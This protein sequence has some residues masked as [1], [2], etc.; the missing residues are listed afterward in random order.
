M[1]VVR[2]IHKE[3]QWLLQNNKYKMT[4]WKNWSYRPLKHIVT[5]KRPGR[6]DNAT[7]ND[8]IIGA[9]TETSKKQNSEANHVVAWTISFRA[10]GC[11]IVTLYGHK[12]SSMMECIKKII[13]SME[14]EETIIYFHNLAYDYMFLRKF[15]FREFG[16][17]VK[18]LNTKP[19]YPIS[20]NFQNGLILKDSLILAQRALEKWAK[21]MDVEHQKAVGSWDYDAYRHQDHKFTRS[22][23]KY[24]EYDTLALVECLDK[25]AINLRKNIATLPMTATGIPRGELREIG[26]KLQVHQSY[27]AKAVPEFDLGM[28]LI[29]IYHG[30]FTHSNRH[31]I[32]ETVL[33]EIV[34]YD[35]SSSYPGQLL[36]EKYPCDRFQPIPDCNI[37]Y[38]LRNMENYA[39]M[40]T[41]ILI[42]PRLKDD[43]I[44]MPVL[45]YSKCVNTINAILD[46]GRILA[47]EYV[48]IEINEIDLRMILK[49][50]DFDKHICSDV[51]VATK[52]YL[53]RWF[54]DY[55]YKCYKEKCELKNG[56]PILYN[57][58]KSRLNALYGMCC[59]KP[60][61][62]EIVEDYT[63][64]E[65]SDK[66]LDEAEAYAKYVKKFTSINLY[67]TG[68]WCTSY[69]MEKLMI[70]GSCCKKWIYSDTDSCYGMDWNEDKLALFNNEIRTKL[71]LNNYEPVMVDGRD[72][73]PGIAELDGVYS[74]FRTVGSK[75]YAC[76]YK[77]SGELKITVAGVPKSG[78]KCLNND[79]NNFVQGMIFSG[80]VTGKKQHQYIY[81]EEIYIDEFGDE[82]GDSINLEQCDYLLDATVVYDWESF[83]DSEMRIGGYY[84]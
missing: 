41:L 72:Y 20:I 61:K 50:Y 36:I 48:E 58:A 59:Q 78:V 13:G 10:Y 8:V 40:L 44:E 21:D 12:P 9:D 34:C 42:K 4:Y 65:Y 43:S 82:T 15:L 49:Q 54:T 29:R 46:N 68:V 26:K 18:Q 81:S 73:W 80:A 66:E 33:G 62:P 38:I 3:Q 57:I 27:F 23:L 2:K 75:R 5:R 64:G 60:I 52:D 19:H 77:D 63:T 7:I 51:S 47:A 55:V 53:P 1:Q 71:L 70:M 39:F 74:E 14:G 67:S 69:A 17:P 83:F 6:G 84:G 25:M 76:R 22:E 32:N 30:G 31:Y 24:I 56:D 37:G 11:N 35:F 16:E 28:K 79:I 45:Q